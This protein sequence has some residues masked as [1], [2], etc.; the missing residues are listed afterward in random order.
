M[1]SVRIKRSGMIVIWRP[2]ILPWALLPLAT[3]LFVSSAGR[4]APVDAPPFE[5]S[6]AGEAPLPDTGSGPFDQAGR[7]TKLAPEAGPPAQ[8][9]AASP[10]TAAPEAESA[11]EGKPAPHERLV[12]G[13]AYTLEVKRGGVARSFG[14][15]LLKANDK[16]IVLRR[17]ASGRNDY[18]VPLLSALPKVGGYFR[19]SYESLVE[20]DL[21]IPRDAATIESHHHVTAAAKSTVGERPAPRTK[22]GVFYARGDK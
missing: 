19:R 14:G 2:A 11:A 20:D 12:I 17:I 7:K 3:V 18:G 15:N 5:E 22:C 6:A 9:T 4:S 16:W 1:E 8:G 21:W 13:D 10:G